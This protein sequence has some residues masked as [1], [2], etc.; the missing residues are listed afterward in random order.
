MQFNHKPGSGLME[1]WLTETRGQQI[2]SQS[3]RQAGRQAGRQTD[4]QT[5]KQILIL[6][7]ILLV[8]MLGFLKCKSVLAKNKV[9]N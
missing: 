9:I 6:I 4:R 8:H 5:D 3:E 7:Q 2:D 1:E